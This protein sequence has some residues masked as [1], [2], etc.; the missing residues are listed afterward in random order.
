MARKMTQVPL[1]RRH[2]AMPK[3]EFHDGE[4][5]GGDEGG[6]AMPAVEGAAFEVG[7]SEAGFQFPV[8]V[9]DAPSH[10][11]EPDQGTDRGVDGEV[12]DP[13]VGWFNGPGGP[14]RTLAR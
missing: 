14:Y 1:M 8:V 4:V 13:V 12:G 2:T 10:L 5:G 7:E 3:V 9:L 6:V 11:R